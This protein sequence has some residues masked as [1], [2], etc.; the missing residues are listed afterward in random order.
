VRGCRAIHGPAAFFC[1]AAKRLR[2]YPVD[3]LL[4]LLHQPIQFW[5][6]P[7]GEPPEPLE[8]LAQVLDGGVSK[9]LGLA[10]MEARESFSEM[11]LEPLEFRVTCPLQR[12]H[13]LRVNLR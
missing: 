5:A 13:F 11:S 4:G 7:D 12:R 3:R 9:D 8:K 10:V 1:A 6:A 2:L